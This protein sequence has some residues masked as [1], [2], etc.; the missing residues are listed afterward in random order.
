LFHN[1]KGAVKFV[2]W[3]AE[4]DLRHRYKDEG[5]PR[6]LVVEGG[7][8]PPVCSDPREDWVRAPISRPD[9]DARVRA[10]RFRA[11]GWKTPR[12]D[13][14]GTLY[15]DNKSVAVSSTQ[16]DLMELFVERFGEVVCRNELENKLAGRASSATRNSLDLHIMRLRRRLGAVDLAIR[17]AWGRGYMLEP[18]TGE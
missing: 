16:I 10:L 18:H 9:L 17:T 1:F 15:Y 4:E 13:A 6:L 3:P 11:Y 8:E 5:V 12:L 7:A 14:T 2:R